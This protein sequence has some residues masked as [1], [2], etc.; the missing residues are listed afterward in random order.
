M[1]L[2]HQR[3]IFIILLL[4]SQTSNTRPTPLPIRPNTPPPPRKQKRHRHQN[5]GHAPEN[6]IAPADADVVVHG[7]HEEREG[8]REHGAQEHVCGD[9]AGA[10]AGEGVNEIVEGGLED[11]GEAD[12]SEEDADYG[13]PV[14]YFGVGGPCGGVSVGV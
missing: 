9:G 14:V 5:D 8:A 1:T 3:S 10:V 12:A 4:P 13:G 6:R 11:G 7:P 2:S